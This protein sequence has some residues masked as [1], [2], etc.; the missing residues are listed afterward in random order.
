M[1]IVIIICPGKEFNLFPIKRSP[2]LLLRQGLLTGRL[3]DNKV[4]LDKIL[5]EYGAGQ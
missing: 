1:T 4:V 5:I 3:P 2:I